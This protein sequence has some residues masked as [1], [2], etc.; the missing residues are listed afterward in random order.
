MWLTISSS[1]ISKSNLSTVIFVNDKV[2]RSQCARR[3]IEEISHPFNYL[4][5]ISRKHL[6]FY[7]HTNHPFVYPRK[8]K[9][10]L[11]SSSSYDQSKRIVKWLKRNLIQKIARCQMRNDVFL[12]YCIENKKALCFK[13]RREKNVVYEGLA[14][15]KEM[16][17]RF[18]DRP[19]RL[20]IYFATIFRFRR[21][22]CQFFFYLKLYFS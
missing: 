12:I 22:F 14:K 10:C 13:D 7:R 3:K 20:N 5:V 19:I 2:E 1:H 17:N 6:R 9:L 11:L 16:S 18:T 15:K 8:D 4:S 21:Y